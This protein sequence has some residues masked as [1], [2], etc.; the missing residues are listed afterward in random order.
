MNTE[1]LFERD[2]LYPTSNLNEPGSVH[3]RV[4]NPNNSARIPVLIES[5]TG[6]SPLNYLDSILRIMQSDIFDRIF[7]DVRRTLNLYIKAAGDIS[8]E[9]G[10]KAYVRVTFDGEKATLAGTDS[11]D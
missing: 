11:V 8:K 4:F 3:I 5:K 6:H 1:V 10:G 9:Y 7:I 2:M